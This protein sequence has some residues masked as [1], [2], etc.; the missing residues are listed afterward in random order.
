MHLSFEITSLLTVQLKSIIIWNVHTLY[1]TYIPGSNE[2]DD[3]RNKSANNL[4]TLVN[5]KRKLIEIKSE[6][7]YNLSRENKSQHDATVTKINNVI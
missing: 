3:L 2:L 5:Y 4:I 1:E 6:I 7:I